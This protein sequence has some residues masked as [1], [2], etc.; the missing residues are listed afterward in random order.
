MPQLRNSGFHPLNFGASKR[1]DFNS[2][3]FFR[4]MNAV[5]SGSIPWIIPRPQDSG[6]SSK[7]SLRVQDRFTAL[8][9]RYEVYS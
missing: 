7:R 2:N 8:C 9:G 1:P 4:Q 6:I 3:E 5:I